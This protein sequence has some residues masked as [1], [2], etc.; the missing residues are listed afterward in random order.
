M[1]HVLSIDDRQKHDRMRQISL[2][3][4]Y[5][6]YAILFLLLHFMTIMISRISA[7]TMLSGGYLN[8]PPSRNYIAY[9]HNKHLPS[10]TKPLSILPQFEPSPHS[11]LTSNSGGGSTTCGSIDERDYDQPKSRMN[12]FL[13]IN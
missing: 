5:I 2:S 4:C 7:Q 8:S 11:L 1:F 3:P 10:S 12:N 13:I 6:M 9:L